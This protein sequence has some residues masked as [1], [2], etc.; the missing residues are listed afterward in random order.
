[1][2][3]NSLALVGLS[4]FLVAGTSFAETLSGTIKV[5]GSSTVYPITEAVAEEFGSTH[6]DV[7]VTVGIS[8]TGGGFKK[9]CA[10][11][12]DISDASRPIKAAEIELCKKNGIEYIELPIAYDALTVVVN[13]LNTW[14]KTM[15]TA[16]LKKMWEPE[17]QGK[18]TKWS[19]VNPAWPATPLKLFGAGVDSGTYDYF[20]EAVMG[21]EDASRGDY[22]S[23]EDDNVLVQGVTSDKNALGFFGVAYYQENKSKLTAVSIDDLNPN[24]GEGAQLPT[25][26]NVLKGVYQPLARP[27]FIYVS[28]KAADKPEVK[29]FV[30]FYIKQGES[31]TKEVGYVPLQS[32]VYEMAHSRFDGRVV[33]SLFEK[34]S[35][36]GMT[37]EQLMSK[38]TAKG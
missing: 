37:L 19:D 13:P 7:K 20:T 6:P 15:T 5:D 34:G 4:A 8:G 35:F 32:K 38:E 28:K 36:I 29:Q 3:R 14:A 2:K 24:N 21:K 23:S 18:I 1:M 12:T 17:A 26:E 27:L 30:S 10:G 9:F 25:I 31:L 11:E 16:E 22:T 33:G